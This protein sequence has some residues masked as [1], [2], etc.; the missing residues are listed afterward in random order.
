MY[1][2]GPICFEFVL[3]FNC[4]IDQ[5][6]RYVDEQPLKIKFPARSFKRFLSDFLC[7]YKIE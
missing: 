1:L 4:I 6:K 3:Q 2:H 5:T 7:L